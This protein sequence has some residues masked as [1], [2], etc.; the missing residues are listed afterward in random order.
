V[1]PALLSFLVFWGTSPLTGSPV[2]GIILTLL[3]QYLCFNLFH[4]D[5]LADTADA[6]LGAFSR[7]QRLAILKDSRIGVYGFFAALADLSLKAAV[8]AA[9][10]PFFFR[11]PLCCFDYPLTG[12]FSAALIPCLAKPARSG[13]LGALIKDA[14]PSRCLGGILAGLFLWAALVLGIAGAISR[15][16]PAGFSLPFAEGPIPFPT[17]LLLILPLVSGVINALFFA[18][19]YRN[20]LGGYTGDTLGAAIETGELLH[21]L[22]VLMGLRIWT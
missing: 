22:I 2:I 21:L 19:L 9:L 4:L 18:R 3:A 6:F 7:E 1:I 14:R 16:T 20:A 10:A 5:G 17:A 11:F 15:F 12:R 13:G 8:M